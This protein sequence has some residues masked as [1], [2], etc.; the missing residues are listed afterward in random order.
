MIIF[1][2]AAAMKPAEPPPPGPTDHI[3]KC[4]VHDVSGTSRPVTIKLTYVG[5]SSGTGAPRH[6]W[7]IE[8]DPQFFPSGDE[9][10]MTSEDDVRYTSSEISISPDSFPKVPDDG[11]MYAVDSSAVIHSPAPVFGKDGFLLKYRLD[12]D[13]EPELYSVRRKDQGFLRVYVVNQDMGLEP[14]FI[15]FCDI[16]S[17][18]SSGAGQ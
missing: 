9:D 6:R 2:S 5:H 13:M 11:Q 15:G 3:A 4:L 10:D 8:A 12:F 1:V 7:T 16:T 18:P 17:Q 14:R